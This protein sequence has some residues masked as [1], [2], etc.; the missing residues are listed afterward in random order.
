MSKRYDVVTIED[1]LV[2]EFYHCNPEFLRAHGFEVGGMRPVTPEEAPDMLASIPLHARMSGGS[3][4]NTVVQ[5]KR[6]GGSST[7]FCGLVGH[8]DEADVFRT[9]LKREGVDLY[10]IPAQTPV[11]TGRCLIFITPGGERTMGT[12]LP[13]SI[14]LKSEDFANLPLEDAKIFLTAGYRWTQDTRDAFYDAFARTHAA[15][16]KVAFSLAAPFCVDRSRDDFLD[17]VNTGRVDILFAN[18]SEIQALYPDK[19][20]DEIVETLKH[21]KCETIAITKGAEGSVIFH[22]GHV[23]EI[24][25][26]PVAADKIVDLAG[27][28]DAYAAGVLHGIAKDLPIEACGALGAKWSSDVIQHVGAREMDR[29]PDKRVTG[30]SLAGP[31]QGRNIT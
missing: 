20:W 9:D 21:S 1:A 30:V 15:G 5:M 11:N 28:G 10:E 7:A 29:G 2:D 27:A 3:T 13:E 23:Y 25:P 31:H 24:P 4:A 19:T 17:F 22:R 26:V 12:M 14:P 8:G 18:S 6:R 16:G